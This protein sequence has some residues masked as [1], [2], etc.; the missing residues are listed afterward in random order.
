[1]KTFKQFLSE[2]PQ[3]ILDYP[4]QG[5]NWIKDAQEKWDQ[6][7]KT[8]KLV[9]DV[10][11]IYHLGD[12]QNGYFMS[13]DNGKVIYFAKYKPT[14]VKLLDGKIVNRQVFVARASRSDSAEGA[15]RYVFFNLILKMYGA[16][17]TDTKQTKHGK[18]FWIAAV[19]HALVNKNRYK[20]YI[21]F[22]FIENLISYEKSNHTY[23]STFLCSFCKFMCYA[24][25]RR[26]Q[27]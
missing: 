24:S 9:S 19:N 23:F 1:M 4:E 10:Y 13:I 18:R 2:Q 25:A 26:T 5:D 17:I 7:K 12:N 16:M 27:P 20:I 8:A 22:N 6:S 15:P 21:L 11:N 14:R 3:V